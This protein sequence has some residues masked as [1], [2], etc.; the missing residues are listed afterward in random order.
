MNSV[1]LSA[2]SAWTIDVSPAP[3]KSE[4]RINTAI[5]CD[6]S[7]VSSRLEKQQVVVSVDALGIAPPSFGYV[8]DRQSAVS[9]A[10]IVE[11][12]IAYAHARRR[13]GNLS[14]EFL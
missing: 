14:G 2:E 11:L 4:S 1:E 7:A 8:Q 6:S 13:I 9:R 12:K 10:A 3:S 5:S